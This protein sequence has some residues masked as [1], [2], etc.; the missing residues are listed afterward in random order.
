[1][2][3]LAGAIPEESA[4][5]HHI[6]TEMVFAVATEEITGMMTRRSLYC[7]KDATSSFAVVR[8]NSSDGNVWQKRSEHSFNERGTCTECKGTREELEID[9]RDNKAYGFIHAD[10]QRKIEEEMNMKFDVIVGNPPY[11]MS[12]GGGGTNDTPLY[13]VFV[14]EAIKLNPRHICM[15]VPSRWMAGGRG[16]DDF[17][18]A[19]LKDKRV[20]VLVDYPNAGD[21]FP[22]VE[23]QSGVCYFLW[24]ADNPGPCSVTLVRGEERIG[25]SERQLDEFDIFVRDVRALGILRKVL[26]VERSGV[27]DLV[28]GDTPFG[29][30]SNFKGYRKGERKP[31]DVKLHLIENQKRIEKWMPMEGITKNPRLIGKWKVLVPKAYNGGTGLPHRIIGPSFV[32]GP[33]NVCTQ[34]YLVVGPFDTKDEAESFQ[35]YI[36]TRFARFL[37][38]LRKISQDAMKST[39]GWVPQ[40]K[41]DRTWTD[42]ILSKM[43]DITKDELAYIE[44]M[45]KEITA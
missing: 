31:G 20:R 10:G 36:N 28:S 35:S 32:V 12:G 23:I 4:R 38:S 21:L 3:G 33:N 41:W 42:E 25:P 15:I 29:L 43:Y 5:L 13:N 16:L 9:G 8:F 27:A 1:M 40:Q 19:M 2:A 34:S 18:A 14:E 39:Y 37:L 44:A 17:R 26:K 6:L 24:D 7:S 30:P 45:V 11:Q 22:G